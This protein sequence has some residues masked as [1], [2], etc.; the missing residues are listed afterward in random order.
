MT[1]HTAAHHHF[2]EQKVY[3]FIPF[4]NIGVTQWSPP[5]TPWNTL[6]LGIQGLLHVITPKRAGIVIGGAYATHRKVRDAPY[7]ALRAGEVTS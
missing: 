1:I 3:F 4:I 2:L 6:H 7:K 5:H